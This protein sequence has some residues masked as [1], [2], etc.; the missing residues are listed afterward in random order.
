MISKHFSIR[1][2]RGFTLIEV[3]VV[4]AIIGI[5]AT[6]AF[7]A[8]SDYIQRSRITEATTRLADFRV[9]MEQFFLDNRTYANGAACGVPDPAV[10]AADSFAVT[11]APGAN[12]TYTATATGTAV[13]NMQAFAY[14]INQTGTK[15]TTSLPGT[16][17]STAGCWV[18][19]KD[20][21][22]V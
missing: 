15:A 2:E 13:G 17:T 6:I 12:N 18:V 16:W 10:N 22:C 7:P 20:G 8:Y 14:T 1:S 3:M 21:S 19:R 11:C 5:L 4:V 9:R